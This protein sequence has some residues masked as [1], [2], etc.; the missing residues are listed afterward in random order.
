MTCKHCGKLVR[1]CPNRPAPMAPAFCRGWIHVGMDDRPVGR[2][3]CDG[4]SI[5]PHAEPDSSATIPKRRK[6][7]D[8]P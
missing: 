7:T 4:R 8:G 3:Y 2:H 6:V 5:N 1:P